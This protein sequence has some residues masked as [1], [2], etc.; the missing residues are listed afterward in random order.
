MSGEY[1]NRAPRDWQS[2]RLKT[3]S[4][5][6]FISTLVVAAVYFISARLSLF[7]AFEHTNASPIWPPTGIALAAVLM[8][9]YRITPGIF[10]GACLANILTLNGMGLSLSASIIAASTTALGSSLEVLAG[11]LM[12]RRFNGDKYPFDDIKNILIF[13]IFGALL[14][15]MISAT[16]GATSFCAATGD[17]VLYRSIWLTWW[18]GDATGA[19]LF[20]PLLLSLPMRDRSEWKPGKT[21]EVM[22][23]FVLLGVVSIIVYA[24]NYPV[25]FLITPVLLWAI[26]RFD[27]FETSLS[28]VLVSG[29]AI[30]STMKTSNALSGEAL[31]ETFLFIQSYLGVISAMALFLSVV[32]GEQKRSE[33]ALLAEKT[34][35]DTVINSIPGV[36]YVLDIEGRLVRWNSFLEELNGL[37]SDGMRGMDSLKNIHENDKGLIAEKIAEAFEKGESNAEGRIT[38]KDGARDLLFTGRRIDINGYPYVVGTGIDITESKSA[39]LGLEEYRRSL[40]DMVKERTVQLTAINETLLFEVRERR[41]IEGVLTESEKKYRDLVEGANSVILRWTRDGYVTFINKFAQEFFGYPEE[42]ILGK[43]IMET[44][45]PKVESTGR[46]LSGVI[47]NLI[48]NPKAY[49]I[50]E[51]ENI[52]KDG[53]RVWIA[54]TNTPILDKNGRILEVLSVGNDIT[55]RKVAEDLLKSTL[56]ELES[57]KERAEV[58]DRLKSAFLATMSHE[59]RTPL[60]SI[61]GF[62]GIILQGYVGPLND[63][64]TKQLNMVR[65]SANH[66][67]SLINDVLDI[68]KIEAGQL[69]V[70]FRPFN[71]RALIEQAVQSSRPAADKKSLSLSVDISTDVDMIVSDYRRVEQ[72]LLNLLSNAIKFTEH[73]EVGVECGKEEG[74]VKISVSDSGIGIKE[75][76]MNKLFKAFQQIDSG[77]TR[78]YDGTGLGLHI[79]KKLAELLNGRIW[80][81][82]R[83]ESGSTFCFTLPDEKGAP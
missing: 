49:A 81:T 46:D 61:I 5:A 1:F 77:T 33:K 82:S 39:Q 55:R 59:L 2:F 20:A 41:K 51:N 63:E 14:S 65:N 60:N 34:F 25:K 24:W 71:L 53:E 16:I 57:S 10:A 11:V 80:A 38:T 18:L 8:F 4:Q 56:D 6:T 72:I 40:E 69:Q 28:V 15:T 21:A 36:F 54:W 29:I 30:F 66:L 31:N 7:L 50:N 44:I 78:R 27:L 19:V 64:Q 9:G 75:E 23:M 22:L 26:L 62:T 79:C 52:K 35:N 17:W 70:S 76:D 73:G 37:P 42:E 74:V 3:A 83:L 67:L 47:D 13:I 32:V 58:S 68:S 43:N 45:V 12:I 48:E